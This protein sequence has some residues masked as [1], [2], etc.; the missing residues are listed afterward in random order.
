MRK[1]SGLVVVCLFVVLCCV[2]LLSA[3][4]HMH[5]IKVEF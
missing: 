3:L 1:I 4:L 5:L 2:V